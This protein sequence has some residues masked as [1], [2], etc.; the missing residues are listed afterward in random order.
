MRFV[1]IVGA[2]IIILALTLPAYAETQSVKVSGEITVRG[3]HRREFDL[4]EVARPHSDNFFMTT[5]EVQIDADLTDNVSTVIRIV[6]QR[7]WGDSDYK[8][9]T[10]VDSNSLVHDDVVF[11]HSLLD[12]G[13]DLAYI[14]IKEL[15]FEPVTVRIGRQDIWFGRGMIIGVNQ[16]D[17]GFVSVLTQNIPRGTLRGIGS[18]ELTAFNAFDAVRTTIDFEK[19]APF[20]VDLVYF[21]ND[22][23]HIG[24]EDDVDV[25]GVNAGYT[26][27]VYN[28]EAE[29]YYW[30]KHNDSVPNANI[31]DASVT[32]TLGMRG[33][34][35]PN[36][37]FV[38]GGEVAGQFGHYIEN[39]EQA[40]ER[41]REAYMINAFVEYLGWTKYM[42]SPKVGAE[43][44]YTTGD[45]NPGQNGGEYSAWDPMYRGYFPLLIRP[46]QGVYYITS[47][48]PGGEDNGMTNQHEFILSGSLQPLDDITFEAKVAGYFFDET[49][50][51]PGEF[52]ASYEDYIGSEV[53][54]LTTYDYTEDVTF[55]L[56]TAW[57][58]PGDNYSARE[59]NSAQYP[60][61][62][63]HN[64]DLQKEVASE[65][66][67][68][69]KVS[70]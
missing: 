56:L 55:S 12:L 13:I 27:D 21:K 29:A 9:V 2:V 16:V 19:Y 1:G 70:F 48:F 38:F 43:W 39:G 26:W 4:N 20:V 33:S 5:T 59:T 45:R 63:G 69:C 8:Q 22:E 50:T 53:D 65:V 6:N 34:F 51:R 46:F 40:T 24:A 42:Y 18:P 37:E 3:I 64:I 23:G 41:D 66:I 15:F 7:N 60:V 30:Y 57:F 14:Q 58:F 68:A 32:N 54:L 44:I 28:A 47:R 11:G 61:I 17:P 31:G 62:N 10:Y 67:G 52:Y 35:M 25:I 49:P 36:E